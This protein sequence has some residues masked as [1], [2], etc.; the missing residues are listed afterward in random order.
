MRRFEVGDGVGIDIRTEVEIMSDSIENTV[1]SLVHL[2]IMLAKKQEINATHIHLALKL[3]RA[4]HRCSIGMSVLSKSC[5]RL[6]T[7][8]SD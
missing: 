7:G 6:L 2:R 8:P 3:L 5:E 1:Q 4:Q